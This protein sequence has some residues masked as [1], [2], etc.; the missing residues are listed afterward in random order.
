[1]LMS[2]LDE[3]D[4]PGPRAAWR[5]A[6]RRRAVSARQVFGRHPWAMGL[7]EVRG[8]SGPS[9][10][11]YLD[12]ILGC[13]RSAGFSVE[14]AAHAFWV[15][16]SYVYGAVIQ[17]AGLSASRDDAWGIEANVYPWL[18]EAST[19]AAQTGA[20]VDR[21]FRFGLELLLDALET[22]LSLSL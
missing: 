1:M 18:A 22:R 2:V 21:E 3:I 11:R 13:L 9:V 8:L 5:T 20:S 7:L 4:L 16:D 14:D 10:G 17:E 6:M 12:T 19:H 15:L